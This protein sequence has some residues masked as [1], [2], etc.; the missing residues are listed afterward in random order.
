MKAGIKRQWMAF[1]LSASLIMSGCTTQTAKTQSYT[2]EM[3]KTSILHVEITANA[4]EWQKMLDSGSDEDYISADITINE[5]TVKNV[6]I[7]PKGNSSRTSVL[8]NDSTDRYSFKIKFDAFVD[9][10][11]WLGLDKLNLNNNFSDSSSMKEYLSYDIMNYIGVDSPLYSYADISVN[12][13]SWG[14][15]LAIEDYDGSYKARAKNDMG[16]LYKPESMGDQGD[17]GMDGPARPEMAQR[18]SGPTPHKVPA[19]TEGQQA[20]S[21][22]N[23]TGIAGSRGNRQRPGGNMTGGMN[24]KDNGVSLIYTDDELSSYSAI[25]GN[26]KTKADQKDDARVVKAIKNLNAGTDLETYVDVDAT[27]RYLAAHTIVVNLDSYSGSFG[28]NYILYENDGQI[29]MLPWDY[30]MAFGGSQ[31]SNASSAVN[32]PIDT[33]VS[34]VSMENRPMISKLLEVP[35]YLAQYHQ[36]LRDII[37]GYFAD[38]A[39]ETKVNEIDALIS[40]HIQ[41]DPSAFYTYEKYQKAVSTLKTLGTLRAESVSGQLDGSIPNTSEGQTAEPEKLIDAS[42]V[43]M[44]ALGSGGGP[45]GDDHHGGGRGNFEHPENQGQNHTGNKK[46]AAAPDAPK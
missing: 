28:H 41:N 9:N 29:S 22:E 15:Y 34:G 3:D 20:A 30:N 24:G 43:D 39:F 36:Y 25:F 40:A 6:G 32:F 42:S 37:D 23:G 18:D 21:S 31:S 38:G 17:M 14:F 1:I 11:T 5:T 16:E 27:L 45:G 10:Q 7:R 44:S 35:E 33:P 2:Q 13:K 12:G 19:L 4:D 26:S 8:K 46:E